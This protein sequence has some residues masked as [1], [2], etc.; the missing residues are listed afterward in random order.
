[1]KIVYLFLLFLFWLTH[2]IPFKVSTIFYE[3]LCNTSHLNFKL[4]I[5]N[6]LEMIHVF[7]LFVP[8][9]RN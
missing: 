5:L 9:S 2:I 1:M 6:D 8:K 7:Y 3:N 4:F